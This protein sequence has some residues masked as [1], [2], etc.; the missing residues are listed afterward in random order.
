MYNYITDMMKYY[1]SHRHVPQTTATILK[2]NDRRKKNVIYR[3]S[4]IFGTNT[5]VSHKLYSNYNIYA[6]IQT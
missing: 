5:Q 6:V 2:D 3:L 1:E 4:Y